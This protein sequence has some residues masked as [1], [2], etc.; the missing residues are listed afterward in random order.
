MWGPN[1]DS[2]GGAN[3]PPLRVTA[4]KETMFTDKKKC[5][6]GDSSVHFSKDVHAEQTVRVEVLLEALEQSLA[7]AEHDRCGGDP[8][9]VHHAG[10][11]ALADQVGAAANRNGADSRNKPRSMDSK[12]AY[13]PRA[14]LGG[15]TTH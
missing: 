1:V 11:Q 6:G 9:L 7:T 8:Q 2:R 10:R 4:A 15:T 14:I 5:A 3:A 12:P 13:S